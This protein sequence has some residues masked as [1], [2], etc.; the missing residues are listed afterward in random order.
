MTN[1]KNPDSGPKWPADRVERWPIERLI[2]D[3]RN[4]RTHS[5]E[6]VAQIAGSMREW[7][8]TNPVLVDE[9]GSVIAGH[10]RILAARQL[11]FTEVPVMVAVGWTEAQRRAY[12]IADNQLGLN[13]G[14]DFGLLKSELQGLRDWDFD[15]G[16][17][18]FKDLDALLA[19]AGLTDPEA[20][21]EP[22]Q[23]PVSAL[24]D[25]MPTLNDIDGVAFQKRA[26]ALPACQAFAGRDRQNPSQQTGLNQQ[27]DCHVL[28]LSGFP[29]PPRRHASAASRYPGKIP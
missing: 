24:G 10:G 19:K 14:W 25:A 27:R 13:A 11:G 12:L 17:L 26:E 18:G 28:Q 4:A 3:A 5:A 6:Q 7:G 2:P 21:P 15:L 29:Q 23:V 22:P 1:P 20:A 9:A 16:L 8:W